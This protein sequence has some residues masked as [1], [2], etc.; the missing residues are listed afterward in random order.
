MYRLLKYQRF[1]MLLAMYPSLTCAV[2]IQ[3]LNNN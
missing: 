3:N 1:V 2:V